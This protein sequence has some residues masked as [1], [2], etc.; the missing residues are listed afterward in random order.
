MKANIVWE[1]LEI[2]KPYHHD[3][4]QQ[5]TTTTNCIS[6]CFWVTNFSVVFNI[7]FLIVATDIFQKCG[8][9]KKSYISQMYLLL[10]ET[11]SHFWNNNNNKNN[12]LK[13]V[14]MGSNLPHFSTA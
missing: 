14:Q 8:Y 5:Q 1:I 7:F 11:N 12:K 6:I 3:Q 2:N 4:Q 9:H 13:S 10:I